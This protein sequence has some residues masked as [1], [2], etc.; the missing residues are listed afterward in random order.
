MF[1][2]A[3]VAEPKPHFVE[4]RASVRRAVDI[5]ATLH[6][7]GETQ[8]TVIDDLSTGG[9]GLNGA[10]GIYANQHV[11]IELADGRRL[12][13]KVAWWLSGCCGIQFAQPISDTDPLFDDVLQ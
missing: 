12:S 7:N 6:A 3:A 10:I 9:A 13:G 1:K 5:P 2:V 4:R 8:P 11:E